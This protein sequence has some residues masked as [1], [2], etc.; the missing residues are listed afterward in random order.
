MT[1]PE[2]PAVPEGM[3]PDA[4]A[5]WPSAEL[6]DSWLAY[7]VQLHPGEE[8]AVDPADPEAVAAARRF[9]DV[10]G[11]FASGVTV[12]TAISN[13]EPV[14]LTCQSFSSV[15]LDP[16]LVLFVPARTSRA[17]PAIQRSGRFC[18]NFL[19]EH[20]VDVSNQM[21]SRG[22]DK[23][24]GLGWHPSAVTGSPVIEGSVAHVDCT[25]HAVHEAGDHWIVIGRVVDLQTDEADADPLLFFKGQYRTVR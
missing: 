12:V 21:A 9:R 11:R 8:A 22:A 18:V 2:P 13:G 1:S 19:A 4:A 25:I 3:R 20:Q 5:T 16:P 23:Y 6:I 15:S 7:D 10:L 17:W 24:A 14:G